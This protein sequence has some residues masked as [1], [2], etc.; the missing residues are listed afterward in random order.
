MLQHERYGISCV[1]VISTEFINTAKIQLTFHSIEK[2]IHKIE[3]RKLV[4]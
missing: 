2:T 3:A 4:I 1:L